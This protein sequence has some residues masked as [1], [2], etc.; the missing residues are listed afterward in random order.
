MGVDESAGVRA[1]GWHESSVGSGDIR[2]EA[3]A[4]AG[5]TDAK[6]SSQYTPP[7]PVHGQRTA[8]ERRVQTTLPRSSAQLSQGTR[9]RESSVN[10]RRARPALVG[11]DVRARAY[12]SRSLRSQRP[13]FRGAPVARDFV[14]ANVK[15]EE[16]PGA[17]LR[18][19]DTRARRAVSR[20]FHP[21]C[22]VSGVVQERSYRESGVHLRRFFGWR[23]HPA[24][25]RFARSRLGRSE[26]ASP[27]SSEW[28]MKPLFRSF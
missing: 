11:R 25:C 8:N 9:G 16:K 26:R 7:R 24:C 6:L 23:D 18:D 27:S 5:R 13:A 22:D 20:Q 14:N 28:V 19:A 12:S 17:R 15:R 21:S 4:S 2:R 1:R 10:I 3:A